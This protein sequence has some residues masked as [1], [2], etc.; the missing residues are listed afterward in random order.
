V[1]QKSD[2]HI[3]G[4]LMGTHPEYSFVIVLNNWGGITPPVRP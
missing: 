3:T 1:N 2:F 4:Q